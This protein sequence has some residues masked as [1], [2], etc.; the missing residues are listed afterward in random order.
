MLFVL[1]DLDL[2]SASENTHLYDFNSRHGIAEKNMLLNK[3]MMNRQLQI[4]LPGIWLVS[5]NS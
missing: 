5:M 2:L 4:K 3:T 1:L